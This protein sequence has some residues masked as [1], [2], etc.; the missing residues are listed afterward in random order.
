MNTDKLDVVI[1]NMRNTILGKQRL[2]D[3]WNTIE[4]DPTKPIGEQLAISAS[5][6]Y[7]RDNV[8]ELNR[9][10]ADLEAARKDI[11]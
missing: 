6:E 1:S 3:R 5:V 7:L 9:I 4:L 11:V 8:G 2:L 10:L